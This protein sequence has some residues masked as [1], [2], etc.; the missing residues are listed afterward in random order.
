MLQEVYFFRLGWSP[1]LLINT[2]PSGQS[3]FFDVDSKL[4]RRPIKTRW[5]ID[6]GR[7]Q[8]WRRNILT[9]FNAFNVESTSKLPSWLL[10]VNLY[11]KEMTKWY[12]LFARKLKLF[13]NMMKLSL[14]VGYIFN[15]AISQHPKHCID[16]T[17][18]SLT[19]IFPS[20]MIKFWKM[21]FL[22]F[23]VWHK[24]SSLIV[25]W[26]NRLRLQTSKQ[27]HNFLCRYLSF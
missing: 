11:S 26:Q 1:I 5:N 13:R 22:L 20:F 2:Q 18:Y 25:S 9:F 4:F 12:S 16:K 10:R 17:Y 27:S 24:V 7:R 8:F 23:Y 15:L 6:L 19:S 14:K 21:H 3:R